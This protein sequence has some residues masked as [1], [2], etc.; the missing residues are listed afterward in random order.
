AALEAMNRPAPVTE[1]D[2]GY[3]QDQA[4]QWV[5]ELVGAQ[6]GEHVADLAAA[7]GGKATAI[8]GRGAVVVALE[9]PRSRTRLVA[10]NARRLQLDQVHPVVADGSRPPLRPGRWDRVLVD[11]PCSGLGSLRRRPDARWRIGEDALDRLVPL[12]RRLLAAGL[13]LLR[14]GGSLT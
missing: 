11:A 14:P 5:A 2:D 7:P 6:P 10:R 4:S 13:G 1:R 8:A 12:Q 9:L 3:V